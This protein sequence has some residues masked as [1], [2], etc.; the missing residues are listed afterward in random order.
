MPGLRGLRL[1]AVSVN[2]RTKAAEKLAGLLAFPTLV[3]LPDLAEMA[4]IVVES[5]PAAHF[6]EVAEPAIERGRIFVPLSVGALLS[7]MDLVERAHETGARIVVPTGA[8]LGLDAVRAA[9]EGKVDSVRLV[10]RK[11]PEG[12]RTAP[13]IIAQVSMSMQSRRCQSL[14]LS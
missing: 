1:C 5:I 14:C 7:R 4:D 10:T 12:L 2:D 6:S 11:P 3:S 8:L 13:H 9:A